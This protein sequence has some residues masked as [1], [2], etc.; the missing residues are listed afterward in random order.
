MLKK[1]DNYLEYF[2]IF[3]PLIDFLT[4]ILTWQNLD[5][6]IGFITKGLFLIFTV[7][8]L[9][10]NY[11]NKKIFLF[12]GI[13]FVIYFLYLILNEMSL[14][15]E[16]T[17]IIKIFYLPILILFFS[18]YENK[19]L[20]KKTI[21]YILFFY[22]ILYLVPM[23]LGMGHNINEV[24][25]NKNLY[26]SYFYIGNELVNIFVV[27]LPAVI[28][29]LIESNSY[30]LKGMFL[31]LLFV[32]I[33]LL[34]TKAFYLS[35]GIIFIYFIIF[36]Y[37][38]IFK[39]IKKNQ[40]KILLGVIAILAGLIVYVPKMDLYENIK[41]SL[42]Y[43]EIDDVRELLKLENIDHIIFSNRLTFLC[44]INKQYLKSDSIEK[45]LGIGREKILATK[46][47]E[48]DCFDIF[49]SLGIIGSAFY[50]VFFFYIF[51]QAKL[52]NV[53]KFSIILIFLIS[54]FSGHVLLSPMVSTYIALLFLVS[55]NDKGLEKVNILLVSNMYPNDKYPHYGIFVKNTYDLLNKNGF[56]MDLVVIHKTNNKLKKVIYYFKFYL[57]SF[58]KSVWNNYDYIYVHFISHSTRGVFIPFICSKNT[59]LVLNTHGNDI[60]ADYDFEIRNEIVSAKYLKKADIV[61]ASSNYFRDVLKNKYQVSEEKI[62][63][64]PAG[65]VDLNKFKVIKKEE[66][67]EKLEIDKDIKYFG[68]AARIE[69]DKGYDTLLLAINELKKRDKLKNIKFIIVGSGQE[70]NILKEMIDKYKLSTYIVRK[71]LVSQSE[72]INIF[73]VIE[74]FIYPT[75]RKSESLGL[76]G[77]EAMACGA[78]VIGSNK[79]GPG[80]YLVDSKNSI[81]FNSEDYKELATKIEEVLEM[82]KKEKENLI[83]N[84]HKTSEKFSV[85]KTSNI[86]LDVFKKSN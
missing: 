8:Y 55:N 39:V 5:Y 33:C 60:V 44:D 56:N 64:Y 70:E 69:K 4:G 16:I 20:N 27:L 74:A 77:L 83:K 2:I 46:D 80:S 72:L 75:R 14:K 30:L 53:Y 25:P 47:V 21:S 28:V 6:S 37:K 7:I 22:L 81:T 66:A 18:N 76:T 71:P 26:L 13:Y 3:F 63:V 61:I 79:Y 12:M 67:L 10:K 23:F 48:I 35:L 15:I 59:K 34:G 32:T 19:K 85:N 17:N 86:L 49:Y 45:L 11:P 9:L 57:V 65:G 51:K 73:N 29:Y 40:L 52:K 78:L 43:Y 54:C 58:W 1:I 82:K 41:T 68:Y 24:Y 31:V 50:I 42:N 36:Y 62:V 38:D 84:A